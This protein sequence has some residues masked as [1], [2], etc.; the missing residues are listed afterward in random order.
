MCEPIKA[1]S[2]MIV[3][4]AEEAPATRWMCIDQPVASGTVTLCNWQTFR[5]EPKAWLCARSPNAAG[6]CKWGLAE[7]FTSEAIL[8]AGRDLNGGAAQLPT[9]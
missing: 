3:E 6:P 9:L 7:Y 8:A 2:H 5:D 1:G 4:R